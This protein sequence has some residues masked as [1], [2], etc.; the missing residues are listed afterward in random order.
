[1][2]G[3]QGHAAHRRCR[4]ERQVV[5]PERGL[6]V[7]AGRAHA[8][9]PA[10]GREVGTD[11]VAVRDAEIA[12]F[13]EAR[14]DAGLDERA[15]ER[16]IV[17]RPGER[18]SSVPAQS[19]VGVGG[20]R[21]ARPEQCLGLGPGPGRVADRRGPA[22]VVVRRAPDP[23]HAVDR[24]RS[25]HHLAARPPNRSARETGLGSGLVAPV[26]AGVVKQAAEADGNVNPGTSIRSS[27]FHHQYPEIGILG[28]PGGQDAA[29]RAG[30][31]DDDIRFRRQR[32]HSTSGRIGPVM[33]ACAISRSGLRAARDFRSRLARATRPDISRR[34][35]P[36]SRAK[37]HARHPWER[38]HLARLNNRWPSAHCGRNA[39]V[40]RT[41]TTCLVGPRCSLASSGLR[42]R[43]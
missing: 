28:Q 17:A 21:L 27:G 30:P 8:Q 22:V 40:P 31:H 6:E 26:E 34:R 15:H 11:A 33:V 13:G 24:A 9:P 23:D 39:R 38:G 36:C 32:G 1:M 19:R 10:D 35:H 43:G 3:I 12:A 20:R 5:T 14:V 37:F 42:R 16:M 7:G 2:T 25:S 18:H 29:G 41:G 4:R